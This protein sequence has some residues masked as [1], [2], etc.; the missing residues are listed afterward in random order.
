M[1]LSLI[2]IVAKCFET[3]KN[4]IKLYYKVIPNLVEH[5]EVSDAFSEISKHQ[6]K[7]GDNMDQF[8]DNKSKCP[9]RN[10]CQDI[11][12]NTQYFEIEFKQITFRD[13]LCFLIMVKDLTSVIKIQ[14]KLSDE[15]YQDAIES[16]Y[17]HEQMTPLNCILA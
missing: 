13:E 1:K 14:Q 16:N 3:N 10:Q 12:N 8:Y 5:E 2:D 15:M 11:E 7:T 17:S 4:Q 6:T 9:T